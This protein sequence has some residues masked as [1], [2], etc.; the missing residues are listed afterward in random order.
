[1]RDPFVPGVRDPIVQVGDEVNHPEFGHWLYSRVVCRA[2]LLCNTE[3]GT[4][5]DNPQV[6]NFGR[7]PRGN[8]VSL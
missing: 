1:M 5:R 6:S 4:L 2:P 3:C 7:E 8:G